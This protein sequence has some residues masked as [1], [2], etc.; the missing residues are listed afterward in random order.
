LE[1]AIL[2]RH[3]TLS[4]EE[5]VLVLRVNVRNSPTIALN[6]DW[7]LQSLHAQFTGDDGQ[8]FMRRTS[9]IGLWTRLGGAADCN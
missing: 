5:I 3:D 7:L 2:G 6:L 9:K 4:E 1:E 8:S